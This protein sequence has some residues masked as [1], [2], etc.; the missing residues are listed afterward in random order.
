MWYAIYLWLMARS[1]RLAFYA[2]VVSGI[3]HAIV[4]V[5]L[6]FSPSTQKIT[7]PIFFEVIKTPA[8][9]KSSQV[10]SNLRLSDLRPKFQP[11]GKSPIRDSSGQLGA[12]RD[13]ISSDDSAKGAGSSWG[14][15]GNGLDGLKNH[16]ATSLAAEKFTGLL[17][18]PKMLAYKQV[19][20]TVNVR[21]YFTPDGECDFKKTHLSSSD[22]RFN[23]SVLGVVQKYC[24]S[25]PLH[26]TRLRDRNFLDFSI[27]FDPYKEVSEDPIIAGNI[28]FL[29]ISGGQMYGTIRL[30]PIQTN[31]FLL[32]AAGLMIFADPVWIEEF[33]KNMKTG[34]AAHQ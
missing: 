2:F 5:T 15:G 27:K 26:G 33:F 22:S 32:P 4:Y 8:K 14:T 10:K 24:D 16:R 17:N 19:S 18:Y 3:L 34:S 20:G 23:E 21:V 9:T 13:Q 31:P 30:G 11:E 7:H 29:S 28:V 1:N 6:S 12:T 25:N